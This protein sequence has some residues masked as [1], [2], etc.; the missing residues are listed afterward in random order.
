MT[1]TKV[2]ISAFKHHKLFS[3]NITTYRDTPI[4]NLPLFVH[5]PPQKFWSRDW[6]PSNLV[7]IHFLSAPM[8][9]P[10]CNS[11]RPAFFFFFFCYKRNK[12]ISAQK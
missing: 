11:P 8:V 12:K 9:C 3:K 10:N 7:R 6:E 1:N 4:Q 5:F 2:L